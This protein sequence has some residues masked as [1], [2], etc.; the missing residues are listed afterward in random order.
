MMVYCVFA[1]FGVL[2]MDF[3]AGEIIYLLYMLACS[4]MFGCVCGLISVASSFLFV[5]SIYAKFE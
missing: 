3:V 4:I 2:K 1:M 5:W